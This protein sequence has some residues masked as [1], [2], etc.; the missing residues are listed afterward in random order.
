MFE[1]TLSI[2]LGASYTK[3][4]YREN[5]VP[6]AVRSETQDARILLV[7][8]KALIP[9]LAI[10][11]R[12]RTKPWVFGL[13]AAN[14]RP[15]GNMRVFRN[16]KADL[17]R[18]DNNQDSAAAVIVAEHFLGWLKEKVEHAGVNLAKTQT[19]IAMPAFKSFD[20]RALVVAR[21]ME[22]NGW[23]SPLIL[24]A[25]EPHANTIGLFSRG[26][27]VVSRTK[28]DDLLLDYGRMFGFGNEYVR[29]ARGH[30]LL[31]NPRKLVTAIVV[32]IGAFTT[33]VAAVTFN[34][35][36]PDETTD[37][38]QRIEQ[39]SHALGVI[40]D[41]DRPLFEALAAHHGFD[42]A[43][44]SFREVEMVK[45]AIY[46]AETYSLLTKGA[47][48]VNLGQGDD[49]PLV[50]EHLERFTDALRERI[51]PFI[52]REEPSVA[53]LTG[54]GALIPR[55]VEGL[56]KWLRCRHWRIG[57]VDQGDGSAGTAHWCPWAD[58]GE[59][60]H[61]LATALG[62]ASVVMQSA[63]RPVYSVGSRPVA[64]EPP[65]STQ[66]PNPVS[67]RCQGGNKDCCFCG[68]R[69]FYTSN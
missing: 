11:T 38:L 15:D 1:A 29:T 6:T 55:V 27:N 7:D 65:P 28:K 33:D 41:L 61:R 48:S 50:D 25:T 31:E 39:R 35:A 66:A 10:Q 23:E 2:D 19:R 32:D 49:R 53:Y 69:G 17:F 36:A 12:S 40:N 22:L 16:W 59:G 46:R 67:C 60:L 20:D 62:G 54:G 5:C 64:W 57:A 3:V 13:Q 45:Q 4:A 68:G 34:V 42:W 8:G 52:D 14:L 63:S 21:C 44:I 47:G 18:P 24:K 43:E 58:T 9:S 56:K 30:T 51:G 26:R 37:G